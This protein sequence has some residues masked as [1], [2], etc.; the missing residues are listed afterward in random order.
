[1]FLYLSEL[2]LQGVAVGL[3][4]REAMQ[5]L[6]ELLLEV[7]LVLELEVGSLHPIGQPVP[8][9]PQGLQLDTSHNIGHLR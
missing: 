3:S 5:G 6:L 7:R 4:L 2:L 1:M 8:L 9:R